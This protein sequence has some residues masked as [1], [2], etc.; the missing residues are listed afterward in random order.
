MK[1]SRS[2]L[3]C[4]KMLSAV[5]ALLILSVAMLTGCGKTDSNVID[6]EEAKSN[7]LMT[8][9]DFDV[10]QQL[11][12]LY[13][14]QYMYSNKTEPLSLDEQGITDLQTA[15]VDEVKSEIVQYLLSQLTEGVEVTE[16]ALATSE[17]S[18]GASCQS[19]AHL[20]YP[21]T[22]SERGHPRR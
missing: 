14:I 17:A 9:E 3:F 8:I 13:V 11:Y 2:R 15:V 21:R 7:V 1:K 16:Q 22:T 5:I 4:K 12:N 6:A 10:T 18:G 20:M 19:P